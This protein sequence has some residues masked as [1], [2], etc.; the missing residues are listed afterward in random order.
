MTS[1]ARIRCDRYGG[2]AGRGHRPPQVG[3]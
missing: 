3:T 2:S 1:H